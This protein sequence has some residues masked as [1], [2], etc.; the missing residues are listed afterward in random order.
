MS[1]QNRSYTNEF[2]REA[3]QLAMD[4]PSV[5]S[6]AKSLGI[7]EATLHTWVQKAKSSGEQTVTTGDGAVSHVNVEKY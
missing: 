4:S 1:K 7:P 3:V 6:A 2:K 5:I